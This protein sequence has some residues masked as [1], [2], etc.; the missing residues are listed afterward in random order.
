MLETAV[1][2]IITFLAYKYFLE[3]TLKTAI[4]RY[5]QTKRGKSSDSVIQLG[6]TSPRAFHQERETHF[7][8]PPKTYEIDIEYQIPIGDNE[9]LTEALKR[10]MARIVEISGEPKSFTDLFWNHDDGSMPDFPRHAGYLQIGGW[11]L[12]GETWEETEER[13]AKATIE[14]NIK[15]LEAFEIVCGELKS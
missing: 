15:V 13:S 3:H 11:P 14:Q 6:F 7:P 1:A 8:F 2:N 4:L 10:I 5:A 9:G 12:V